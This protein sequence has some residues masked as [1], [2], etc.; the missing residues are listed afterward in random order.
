[1]ENAG[2]KKTEDQPQR[3]YF[4]NS[5]DFKAVFIQLVLEEYKDAI[6]MQSLYK[7]KKKTAFAAYKKF[8]IMNSQTLHNMILKND[9]NLYDQTYKLFESVMGEENDGKREEENSGSND[10]TTSS[11]ETTAAVSVCPAG[12]EEDK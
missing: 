1:M 4:S 2:K 11:T 7:Q 12:S 5:K 10:S 9:P 3:K 8:S 6:K